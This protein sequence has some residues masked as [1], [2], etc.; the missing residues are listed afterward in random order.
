MRSTR[1]VVLAVALVLVLTVQ[2]Q[3]APTPPV[4]EIDGAIF[5]YSPPAD[6]PDPYAEFNMVELPDGDFAWTLFT[7]DGTDICGFARGNPNGQPNFLND[8]VFG[9]GG[10]SNLGAGC[11][12]GVAPSGTLYMMSLSAIMRSIDGGIGWTVDEGL[13]QYG[14]SAGD[15]PGGNRMTVLDDTHRVAMIGEQTG[16]DDIFLVQKAGAT[17]ELAPNN[18]NNNV[19]S[20]SNILILNGTSMDRFAHAT[21][22]SVNCICANGIAYSTDGGVSWNTSDLPFM[23]VGA[24]TDPGNVF[25]LAYDGTTITAIYSVSPSASVNDPA[26]DIAIATS[27]DDGATW[28]GF[29]RI[30]I[31]NG[32][33]DAIKGGAFQLGNEAWGMFTDKAT[34][35]VFVGRPESDGGYS[36]HRISIVGGDF[37]SPAMHQTPQGNIIVTG[38]SQ[39]LGA[40]KV[41]TQ[42]PSGAADDEIAVDGL[43][44]FEVDTTGTVIMTRQGGSRLAAVSYDAGSLG[45]FGSDGTQFCNTLEG[46]AT[47]ADTI[48]YTKCSAG[49][50]ADIISV[51]AVDFSEAEKPD[52]DKGLCNSDYD[53]TDDGFGDQLQIPDQLFHFHTLDFYLILRG[54]GLRVDS[55]TSAFTYSLTDGKIGVLAI[56]RNEGATNDLTSI[57]EVQFASQA[58]HDTCFWRA[59]DGENYLAAVE[60]QSSTSVYRATVDVKQVTFWE[61]ETAMQRVFHSPGAFAGATGID[62]TQN[63][64]V[65]QNDDGEVFVV[66]VIANETVGAGTVLAQ[67]P[68][69]GPPVVDAGVSISIDGKWVAFDAGDGQFSVG[70][71][72][73]GQVVA[74]LDA[75]SGTFRGIALDKIGTVAWIAT[76]D[77]IGKYDI[78]KSTCNLNC[79]DI[80]VDGAGRIITDDGVEDVDGELPADSPFRAAKDEASATFGAGGGLFMA[81]LL[82]LPLVVSMA[83][84]VAGVAAKTGFS[85]GRAAAWGGA[86][87]F[88]A[89]ISLSLVFDL[90][91][92]VQYFA[93]LVLCIGPIVGF[94]WTFGGRSG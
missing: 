27:T 47:Y 21:V 4:N 2:A 93:I 31:S 23:D 66:Q 78:H 61:P 75:P 56:T 90:I 18:C 38:F 39:N 29:K 55:C 1:V 32:T 8:K 67:F 81:I 15:R 71:V 60:R 62:C 54:S 52:N 79:T 51:R 11:P 3:F 30:F 34:G 80:Q 33:I 76:S 24:S 14:I 70:D 74:T 28:D 69:G 86:A 43:L 37:R 26:R 91:T 42:S 59:S 92:V 5:E 89:G 82:T 6:D 35:D 87:G 63:Q 53:E 83:G 20:A 48:F 22:H 88:A 46:V 64:A 45:E 9:V 57:T 77:F 19:C 41:F 50:N 44:A 7:D 49:S 40:W 12:L 94:V 10:T 73:T 16:S 13:S 25:H 85:M 36:W 58:P 68:G 65:I 72:E 17:T 84:A